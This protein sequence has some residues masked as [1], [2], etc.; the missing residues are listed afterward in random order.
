MLV[1]LLLGLAWIALFYVTNGG[2]S[3]LSPIGGWNLVCGFV[4]IVAGVILATRWR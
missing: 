4:L 2:P 1:C 3:W